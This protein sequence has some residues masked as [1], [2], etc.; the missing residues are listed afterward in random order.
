MTSDLPR[1]GLSAPASRASALSRS[2]GTPVLEVLEVSK[3]YGDTVALDRLSMEVAPGQI[4]GFVGPN[5]AGK[6][7]AMRIITG[8]LE[9][10]SGEVRWAGRTAGTGRR[11]HIG[12][13]PEERGLYP[14]MRVDHQLEYFAELHGLDPVSARKQTAAWLERLGVA[15]RALDNVEDL[16]LG[17]QQRIQLAASLV[18]EP[19]LLILDEP[20]SGLDPIGVD[21]LSGVLA[22]VSRERDVPVLFSSHQLDLVEQIC[23]AV[24]II[25]D[26]RLVASGSV[27]E[28]EEERSR[29]Q[30]LLRVE[31]V[32]SGWD[33]A[34]DGARRV[35]PWLFELEERTDPQE[36]LTR[37]RAAGDVLEFGR[38]R[39]RLTEL[40]RDTIGEER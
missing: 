39:P 21:A 2:E 36:L 3:R 28:L 13:M 19:E 29:N 26:G 5:G 37:G 18:F 24:A 15:D 7:T 9:A 33:P 35:G 22:E 14:K 12:Y 25:K 23:D 11:S 31:G 17:N 40:F 4:F 8:L 20:F 30:W 38:Q 10:D 32:D 1:A 6:T 27:K 34:L 16:S